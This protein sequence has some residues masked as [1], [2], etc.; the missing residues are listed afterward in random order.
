MR[1]TR[2]HR[3]RTRPTFGR[4]TRRLLRRGWRLSAV[5]TSPNSTAIELIAPDLSHAVVL[6]QGCW[7]RHGFVSGPWKRMRPLSVVAG[8]RFARWEG[9]WRSSP[10]PSFREVIAAARYW[11]V[12][13]SQIGNSDWDVVCACCDNRLMIEFRSDRRWRL[14]RYELDPHGSLWIP[15]RVIAALPLKPASELS[16]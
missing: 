1:L 15:G 16:F 12:E 9:G 5:I 3:Q 7:Y 14:L 10:G 2:T 4:S 6:S 8:C 11:S 13:S